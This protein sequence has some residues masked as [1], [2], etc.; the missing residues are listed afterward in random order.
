MEERTYKGMKSVFLYMGVERD[1]T[2]YMSLQWGI[3]EF[4]GGWFGVK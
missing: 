4:W 3:G 1:R 2:A